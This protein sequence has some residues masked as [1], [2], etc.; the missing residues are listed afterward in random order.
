MV[1]GTQRASHI[2]RAD[3]S[4]AK[5]IASGTVFVGIGFQVVPQVCGQLVPG[6]VAAVQNRPERWSVDWIF[7]K[8]KSLTS[9]NVSIQADY[10]SSLPMLWNPPAGVNDSMTY[11]VSET[12]EDGRNY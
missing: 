11:L 2:I 1:S 12:V 10:E 6:V 7:G 9:V 3:K 4:V 8:K 5:A